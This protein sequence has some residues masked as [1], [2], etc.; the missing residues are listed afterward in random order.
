VTVI[1][2]T[3]EGETKTFDEQQHFNQSVRYRAGW[4]TMPDGMPCRMGYHAGWDTAP[5]GMPCRMGYRA[6]WDTAPDGIP[7]RMGYCA[8]WDTVPDGRAGLRQGSELRLLWC[9]AT[10]VRHGLLRAVC[11]ARSLRLLRLALCERKRPALDRLDEARQA[12][13]CRTLRCARTVGGPRSSTPNHP[14]RHR[15][16]VRTVC[17][18]STRTARAGQVRSTPT[19]APTYSKGCFRSSQPRGTP[20]ALH[21]NVP[22]PT[23]QLSD[24]PWKPQ[25]G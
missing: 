1:D 11:M 15:R 21:R 23:P 14:N 9:A 20:Y 4:D 12:C 7:C 3:G 22:S 16:H 19:L 17:R 13:G 6:G 5:D 2:T 8:G 18:L 24:C 25:P 10:Q